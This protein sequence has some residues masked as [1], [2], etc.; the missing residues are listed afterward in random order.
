LA[1]NQLVRQRVHYK[2]RLI[3]KEKKFVSDFDL[4]DRPDSSESSIKIVAIGWYLPLWLNEGVV[5]GRFF[6]SAAGGVSKV[7]ALSAG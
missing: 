2:E 7:L 5:N 4:S 6:A 3:E 1:R